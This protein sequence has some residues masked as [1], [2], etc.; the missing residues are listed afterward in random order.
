[1]RSPQAHNAMTYRVIPKVEVP[2]LFLQGRHDDILDERECIDL[3]ELA[4]QGGNDNV[5]VRYIPDAKHDCMENPEITVST[6]AKWV[7]ERLKK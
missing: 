5:E 6:I 2:I 4:R 1:M 7:E 3:A